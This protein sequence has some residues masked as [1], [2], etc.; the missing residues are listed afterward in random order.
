MRRV[1]SNYNADRKDLFRNEGLVYLATVKVSAADRFVLDQLR[2]LW[3]VLE[4]QRRAL[5]PGL[6]SFAQQAPR[7]EGGAG[8]VVESISRAGPGSLGLRVRK[9]VR[10]A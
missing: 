7:L 6:K 2:A 10:R 8:A 1:L 9:V 3:T 4:E 5:G